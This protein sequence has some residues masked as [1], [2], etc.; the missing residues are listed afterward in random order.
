[1]RAASMTELVRKPQLANSRAISGKAAS[2]PAIWSNCCKSCCC[3]DEGVPPLLFFNKEEKRPRY[4]I[5]VLRSAER[6]VLRIAKVAMTGVTPTDASTS[7]KISLNSDFKPRAKQ[8]RNIISPRHW[9]GC[10][11]RLLRT[12]WTAPINSAVAF[13]PTLSNTEAN[14]PLMSSIAFAFTWAAN[15]SAIVER[16]APWRKSCFAMRIKAAA[17]GICD[18]GAARGL[19]T[20]SSAAPLTDFLPCDGF[21]RYAP[22][23]TAWQQSARMKTASSART[24]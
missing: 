23:S 18:G 15:S 21:Q 17:P 24:S 12:V 13:L 5:A 8:L 6:R 16:L 11:S 19:P 14:A 7:D 2:L 1:M 20:D 10:M 3:V 4:S 22:K 9:L